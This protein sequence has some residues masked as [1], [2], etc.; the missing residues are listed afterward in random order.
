M[1]R[2]DAVLVL[3]CNGYEDDEG[4]KFCHGVDNSILHLR[5]L[6][7][8]DYEEI[9][10]FFENAC[11]LFNS[12]VSDFNKCSNILNMLYKKYK[13]IDPKM[14]NKIQYYLNIHKRCKP[15]LILVLREDYYGK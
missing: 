15:F 11:G 5:E 2:I 9:I 14:L 7:D 12:S 8:F 13:V 4:F 10:K 6:N 3:G 1:A